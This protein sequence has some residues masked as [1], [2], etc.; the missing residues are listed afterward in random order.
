[1]GWLDQ[2]LQGAGKAEE[3]EQQEC[4]RQMMKQIDVFWM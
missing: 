2:Y 1:L 3:E 4:K